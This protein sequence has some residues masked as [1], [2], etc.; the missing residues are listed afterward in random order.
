MSEDTQAAAPQP[1]P[2]RETIVVAEGPNK[3]GHAHQAIAS[4]ATAVAL[5]EAKERGE[6]ITLEEAARTGARAVTP[7]SLTEG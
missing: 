6:S 1:D 7:D 2:Y 4:A 3:A 5:T